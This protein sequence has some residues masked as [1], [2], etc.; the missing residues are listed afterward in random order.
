M[1]EQGVLEKQPDWPPAL[2]CG[3]GSRIFVGRLDGSIG[4]YNAATG[5]RIASL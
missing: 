4:I 2:A 5:K 1:K 3:G